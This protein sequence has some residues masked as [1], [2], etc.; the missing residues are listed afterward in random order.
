MTSSHCKP[1]AA[2]KTGWRLWMMAAALAAS[3]P[4]GAQTPTV[5]QRGF[6]E[7][8]ALGF[9]QDAPNDATSLVGDLLIRDEIFA[10]PAPWLQLAAGADVRA[11]SHDQVDARWRVD[12]GDRGILRPAISVR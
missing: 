4:L 2:S 10:T 6:V 12:L 11:N 7:A 9:P 1:S 5:T 8:R 3:T